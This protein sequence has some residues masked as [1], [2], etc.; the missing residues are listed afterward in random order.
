MRYSCFSVKEGGRRKAAGRPPGPRQSTASGCHTRKARVPPG[1]VPR[2]M[3]GRGARNSFPMESRQARFP[4]PQSASRVWSRWLSLRPA[5][6]YSARCPP[7]RP[8]QATNDLVEMLKDDLAY[9]ASQTRRAIVFELLSDIEG[10]RM[11]PVLA[12]RISLHRMHAHRL[13]AL[14]RIKIKPLALHVENWWASVR[15]FRYKAS[16]LVGASACGSDPVGRSITWLRI[17][18][19]MHRRMQ[20]ANFGFHKPSRRRTT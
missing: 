7:K 3:H 18:R 20:A 16:S 11:E 10:A 15:D 12:L 1:S 4:W 9:L 19:T 13:I 6:F 5:L 2:E 17:V 14:I 8:R